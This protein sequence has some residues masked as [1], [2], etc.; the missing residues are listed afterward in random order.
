MFLLS[1]G[2]LL[3]GRPDVTQACIETLQGTLKG[4]QD[5][6]VLIMDNGCISGD[7][8]EQIVLQSHIPNLVWIPSAI[9]YGFP[10]GH[11]ILLEHSEARLH[12]ILNSDLIFKDKMWVE[13][14]TRPLLDNPDLSLI[15]LDG[16]PCT[17][18]AENGYI[19]G[20]YGPR[21]DYIE[22]SCIIGRTE[23]FRQFGLF[24]PTFKY[25]LFEDGDLSMRFRQVGKKMSLA[26]IAHQHYRSLSL[27]LIPKDI[28][29][30][31]TKRNCETFKKRWGGYLLNQQFTNRILVKI[32]SVGIGDNVASTPV[33]EGLRRDHP[34][35]TI[36]VTT[37]FPEVFA[38]NPH[39]NEIY[40]LEREYRYA[41][42]RTIDLKPNYADYEL[43]A[44]GA[45]QIAATT[46]S[47]YQPQLFMSKLEIE[48]GKRIVDSAREGEEIVVGVS[49]RNSR[50][51]WQGK[52]WSVEYTRTLI[53][54]IQETGVSVIELGKDIESTGVADL[55][56]VNQL[57]LR[58]FFSVVANLQV[59]VTIDSLALHVAQAFRV[60]TFALFGAT[61]PQSYI[62]NWDHTYPIWNE[63]LDC[64]GCY[65]R[66]GRNDFNQCAIRTEA[67]MN[68]LTPEKV[69]EVITMDQSS[70]LERNIRILQRIMREEKKI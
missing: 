28:R 20:F 58:E 37:R 62:V 4:R 61:D 13:K 64:V 42:D 49:L 66:R 14:L 9:N 8:N 35:A 3:Y 52:C 32:E 22:G 27:N 38:G 55:D 47:S 56:L 15:G 23:E 11:N 21:F 17:L 30:H 33:L 10:Q 25:F 63:E 67:C 69:M 46:C 43:I 45:E 40:L 5:I 59:L 41:Y 65:Q 39:I 26:R 18:R 54:M 48:G 1:I 53:E 2:I 31:Y 24:S 57:S 6:Q 70:L 68:E 44:A 51:T 34:T 16:S 29:E 50:P 7:K 60:P 12:L 19:R 36:E